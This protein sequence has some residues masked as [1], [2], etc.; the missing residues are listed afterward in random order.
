MVLQSIGRSRRLNCFL[1]NLLCS[2]FKFLIF[3]LDVAA[4]NFD[5]GRNSKIKKKIRTFKVSKLGS[6]VQTKKNRCFAKHPKSFRRFAIQTNLHNKLNN[7]QCKSEKFYLVFC[8]QDK[9]WG[10]DIF[11]KKPKSKFKENF[12]VYLLILLIYLVNFQHLPNRF[13]YKIIFLFIFFGII[14]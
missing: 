7:S 12:T 14:Y 8:S 11:N 9:I 13:R 1:R 3:C 5:S 4:Q 10:R 6:K 2:L